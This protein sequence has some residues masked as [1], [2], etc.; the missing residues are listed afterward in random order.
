MT[1]NCIE[2]PRFC[3]LTNLASRRLGARTLAVSDDFFAAVE[4]LIDDS[5]PV[6]IADKYDDHGKWMDGWESRRRRD[7][8]HDWAIVALAA[9]G[10]IEGIE[11]DTRHF[12][13]NYPPQAC[14]DI[15]LSENDPGLDGPWRT[16]LDKVDLSGD[17]R[18]FFAITGAPE[19]SHV[20]LN[21]FPDGGV[22]RLRVHGRPTPAWRRGGKPPHELSALINGGRIVAYNDAHYGSVWTLLAP[23]RGENMGDGWETRRR[24]QPGHDWMV[25]ALGAS[26]R[27]EAIEIDT[28]HF[29]GNFPDAASVQAGRLPDEA[30]GRGEI[31]R[32][33]SAWPQVLPAQ[34]LTADSIHRFA[35]GD[36]VDA[37]PVSHVR[38]NIFP[39]GGVSRLRVFGSVEED[40]S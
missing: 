20:R 31:D 36:I 37:G 39:D 8:G 40:G 23:G 3:R 11:I 35:G 14:L 4:R 15:C 19:A 5:D 33:S 18:H 32:Q 22:A 34:K 10:R 12:T 6:F 9:P 21:I 26:G 28:C 1:R 16:I 13:G 2:P 25:I 38:L 30:A 29:K 17:R 24:R 7:G 27:I